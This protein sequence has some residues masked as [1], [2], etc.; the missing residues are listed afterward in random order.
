[1]TNLFQ[2]M[3]TINQFQQFAEQFKKTKQDPQTVLDQLVQS[4]K[5]SQEQLQEATQMAQMFKSI[6]GGK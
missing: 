5:V 2:I 3:Q 6:L 1:M 4:G